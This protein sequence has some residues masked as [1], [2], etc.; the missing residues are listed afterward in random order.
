M[1]VFNLINFNSQ[2]TLPVTTIF[3]LVNPTTKNGLG[4]N[5]R[6]NSSSQTAYNVPPWDNE[7]AIC[8]ICFAFAVEILTMLIVRTNVTN[9]IVSFV[10]VAID[11]DIS[12]GVHMNDFVTSSSK[13]N[14]L[15][16]SLVFVFLVYNQ[17]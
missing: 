8:I 12:F 6:F 1:V 9:G 11:L 5:G 14:V 16:F 17:N 15:G 13:G 4:Q 10:I 3:Y 7:L 2:P